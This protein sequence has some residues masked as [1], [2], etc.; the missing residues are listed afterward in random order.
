MT[1]AL[2]QRT[3]P[4]ARYT[5][6]ASGVLSRVGNLRQHSPGR[7]QLILAALL[8]LGLLTGLVAGLTA[9]SASAG[10]TRLA[11]RAQ[12]LLVEAETIYSALADAD[13]TAA[14]AFLAGGLEPVE[15]T[16]R[17]DDDLA[18]AAT[19][20]TDAARLVP[21]GDDAATSV[22]ALAT[23]LAKY[24]A[25]VATARANN[26]QGLPIGASYLSTASQLN[27]DTLQPQAQALFRSAGDEVDAGYDAARSSWWL[28]LLVV[29]FVALGVALFWSQIY[30]SRSTRR[31][32]NVPLVAATGLIGLLILTTAVL[33][34]N[35]RSHLSG[36]D[37]EG[38]G[39]VAA[40]AEMRI[41]VLGERADEALTLAARGGSDK[42][43]DFDRTAGALDFGDDRVVG[44]PGLMIRAEEQH[45]AYV[46][47]HDKVRALDEGGDYDGAV[48]LA[49]GTEAGQAFGDLT[50][51]L[52]EAITDRKAAFTT[53][54]EDAGSGL[55]LLTVLGPLL[56]LAAC[57]LAAI[58]IRARLEEYR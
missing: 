43:A 34:T 47:V 49:V 23:G 27:R 41:M 30:L 35:Q 57:A 51:T 45:T 10:T 18:R 3:P 11:D 13:T 39:P 56:A 1:T 21:A 9:H 38:S 5:P 46:A 19:A 22:E 58:G 54:I 7:L 42:E 33:F 32:F 44:V 37:R 36:A 14:Q 20:L 8:A 24:S 40:L 26:R 31:T 17:Y 55:D 53:Q 16:R 48:K 15:L 52:D 4:A 28:M 6:P 2:A 12:P 25:L 50:G 29:L